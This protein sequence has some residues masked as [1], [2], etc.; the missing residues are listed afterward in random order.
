MFIIQT[1]LA[2]M[3]GYR[4][5]A[6]DCGTADSVAN[7]SAWLGPANHSPRLPCV[8]DACV[9]CNCTCRKS[10]EGKRHHNMAEP[11]LKIL[12]GA[13][14]RNIVRFLLEKHNIKCTIFRESAPIS[15]FKPCYDALT[16]RFLRSFRTVERQLM[17]VL[18]MQRS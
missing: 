1:K 16:S 15:I 7:H 14:S 10:T 5:D 4:G 8:R 2:Y 13:D 18:A 12:S 6:S 3:F 11:C 9:A 17:A